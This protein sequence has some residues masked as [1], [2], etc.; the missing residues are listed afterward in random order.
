MPG[1]TPSLILIS[2][3][4]TLIPFFVSTALIL[5]ARIKSRFVIFWTFFVIAASFEIIVHSYSVTGKT[6]TLII[7]IYSPI[8][9]G[10]LVFLMSTWHPYKRIAKLMKV[11]IPIYLLAYL[12]LKLSGTETFHADKIDYVS[13]PISF[14]LISLFS[15][16]MLRRLYVSGSDSLISS[17]RLWFLFSTAIYY[18]S[19]TLIMAFMYVE[20]KRLLWYLIYSNASLNIFHNILFTVSILLAILC[21]SSKSS[22]EEMGTR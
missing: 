19:E 18:T 16:D 22:C 10:I 4:S 7:Q 3:I 21:E 8:E 1:Q 2:N 6:N 14:L 11:S 9:Y 5:R 15:L 20:S 13:T 17:Y 12:I